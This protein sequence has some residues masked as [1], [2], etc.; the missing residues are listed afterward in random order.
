MRQLPHE[1]KMSELLAPDSENFNLFLEYLIAEQNEKRD[2]M[3]TATDGIAKL[4]HQWA[5]L[6]ELTKDEG[7][8]LRLRMRKFWHENV[9]KSSRSPFDD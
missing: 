3:P 5:L 8:E 9:P 7:N 6:E 1:N 4:Q 2:R